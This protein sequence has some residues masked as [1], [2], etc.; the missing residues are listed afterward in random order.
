MVRIEVPPLRERKEDIAALA[1]Y[2]IDKINKDLDGGI[3]RIDPDVI[4]ILQNYDFPG[5]VRELENILRHAVVMAKGVLLLPEYL[6]A[7]T[8][9]GE[10]PPPISAYR[11]PE[12]LV[13][14]EEMERRYILHALQK[15]GWKK[16]LTCHFLK[17]ARTTL[18]RKLE[19]YGIKAP[20][21]D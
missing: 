15:T 8:D 3:R 9:K 18:D 21:R 1:E 20:K 14:L 17:I 12:E 6:P 5:N 16:K 11:F 13:S 10:N 2:L 4:Q 19:L 7:L